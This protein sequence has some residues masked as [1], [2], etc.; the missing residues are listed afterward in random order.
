MQETNDATWLLYL[1][2]H[3]TQNYNLEDF[4]QSIHTDQMCWMKADRIDP[5]LAVGFLFRDTT[6]FDSWSEVIVWNGTSVMTF[7][8]TWKVIWPAVRHCRQFLRSFGVDS[9]HCCSRR[10]G[11]LWLWSSRPQL[12]FLS[13]KNSL[14]CPYGQ[15]SSALPIIF[16]LSLFTMFR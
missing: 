1:D 12:N 13:K 16:P 11:Q 6:E 7:L 15:S 2:P 4:D 14:K 8:V 5:S 3:T 9:F 10:L